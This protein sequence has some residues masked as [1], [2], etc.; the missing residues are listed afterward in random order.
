MNP[1]LFVVLSFLASM[2]FAMVFH[3]KK[4]YLFY[5][6]L[7]G[8]VTRIVFLIAMSFTQS[9]SIY[10][11]IAAMCASAYAYF[12]AGLK[13]TPSTV[14]LYPTIIPLIPGDLLYFTMEGL[15]NLN[16][17]QF[18]A[19]GFDLLVACIWM[20]LGFVVVITSMYYVRKLMAARKEC[21]NY[22]ELFFGNQ[23][24]WD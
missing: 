1:V 8:A 14:F 20:G 9:R 5:A 18:Y 10:V 7:G 15:V 3:I 23:K 13:K 16:M 17:D 21:A 6:G 19:S 22:Y 2:G 24:F 4:E 11:C 12:M